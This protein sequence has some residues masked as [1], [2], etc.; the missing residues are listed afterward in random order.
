M[1][2]R[3]NT[4]GKILTTIPNGA[5]V[6]LFWYENNSWA[7][8]AYRSYFGF[9]MTRHLTEAAPG[10]SKPAAAEADPNK[11]YKGFKHV[12]YDVAVRPSNPSG[13]VNMRWAPSKSAEV[14]CI[15][16]ADTVLQVLSTNG[17]WSQVYDALTDQCGFIMNEYLN[18]YLD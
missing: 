16:Y 4:N 2:S 11:M 9:C 8:V 15:Y 18:K 6:T 5:A 14:Q 10:S 17:V 12:R 3:P 7:Y 13:F 1:R